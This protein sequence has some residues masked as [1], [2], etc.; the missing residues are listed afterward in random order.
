MTDDTIERLRII[1]REELQHLTYIDPQE[2]AADHVWIGHERRKTARRAETV[3][4][5]KQHVIGWGL[6]VGLAGLGR[7]VYIYTIESLT[8]IVGGK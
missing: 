8:R 6:V 5:I 4:K 2:H 7:V 3:E 1:L